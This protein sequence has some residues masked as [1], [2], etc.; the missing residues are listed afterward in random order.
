M[1]EIADKEPQLIPIDALA[2]KML[3]YQLK[4]LPDPLAKISRPINGF[5]LFVKERY[6][7][8]A[9]GSADKK[10]TDCIKELAQI[11]KNDKAVQ[12][13]IIHF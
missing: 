13:V 4:K 2:T 8:V 9:A 1:F 10:A 3:K 11:W 5:G 7:S 12:N 6:Q